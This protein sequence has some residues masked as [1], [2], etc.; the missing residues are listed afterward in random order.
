MLC[1]QLLSVLTTKAIFFFSL[2]NNLPH[3]FGCSDVSHFHVLRGI[4]HILSALASK[5]SCVRPCVWPFLILFHGTDLPVI[6]HSAETREQED[7]G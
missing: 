2:E 7:S 4:E 3:F 6:M 5:Q 1:S